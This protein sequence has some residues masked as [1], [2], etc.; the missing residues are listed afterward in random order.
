MA[1]WTPK[2]CVSHHLWVLNAKEWTGVVGFPQDQGA[3][4]P[5]ACLCFLSA[6]LAPFPTLSSLVFLFQVPA[7]EENLLDDKH[8]LK[9]WDAK[10]VDVAHYP[11]LSTGRVFQGLPQS[12]V[13]IVHILPCLLSYPH[14]LPALG[15]VKSLELSKY[16]CEVG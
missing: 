12:T 11:L 9:P 2:V 3:G 14:H 6:L 4:L 5:P 13:L 7:I 1:K 16:L 15:P 8:L 10:K